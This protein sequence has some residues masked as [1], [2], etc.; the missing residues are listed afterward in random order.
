MSI[1]KNFFLFT[2]K[3]KEEAQCTAEGTREGLTRV[4]YRNG[5]LK[6]EVVYKEGKKEGMEKDY[7]RQGSIR[8]EITYHRGLRDGIYRYY[9]KGNLSREYTYSKGRKEGPARRYYKDGSRF[10]F[11]CKEGREKVGQWRNYDRN[12]LLVMEK[13]YSRPNE[14]FCELYYEYGEFGR[15][16][17]LQWTRFLDDEIEK[18]KQYAREY[19]KW[20]NPGFPV[21]E[22]KKYAPVDAST[23]F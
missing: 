10:E 2:R 16:V 17:T 6:K 12:G 13:V 3:I 19:D 1:T 9:A 20:G 11:A 15:I 5:T 22:R 21:S 4:Y 8:R 18:Y 7:S 14:L 23:L